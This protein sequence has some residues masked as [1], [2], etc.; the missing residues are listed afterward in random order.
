MLLVE[1]D[2]DVEGAVQGLFLADE[3]DGIRIIGYVDVFRHGAHDHSGV[4]TAVAA[5]APV[6]EEATQ[7]VLPSAE[8]QGLRGRVWMFQLD[9]SCLSLL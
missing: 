9:C 4:V 8:S 7:L 2:V 6:A 3:L 1:Q 5:V